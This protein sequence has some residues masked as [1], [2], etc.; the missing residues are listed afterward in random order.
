MYLTSTSILDGG[1]GQVLWY[2]FIGNIVSMFPCKHCRSKGVRVWLEFI[3]TVP[4]DH[5]N[6][7]EIVNEFHKQCKG[8]KEM[9][10]SACKYYKLTEPQTHH[11][12][13]NT[14][15]DPK[16]VQYPLATEI[17]M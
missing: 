3:S 13:P 2:R 10:D 15:A 6:P 8:N 1:S 11:V 17:P 14:D 7:T 12:R 5:P 4:L 16:N 9:I